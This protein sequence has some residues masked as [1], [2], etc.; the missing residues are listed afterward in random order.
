MIIFVF[1]DYQNS[2]S[3]NPFNKERQ[4]TIHAEMMKDTEYKAV[5]TVY[6]KSLAKE[7]VRYD[8]HGVHFVFIQTGSL[9][10]FN[11]QVLLLSFVSGMGL[12]AVST[13]IVDFI[14][15]KLFGSKVV[16]NNLKFRETS[17]LQVLSHE[18]LAALAEKLRRLQEDELRLDASANE[19]DETKIT[20]RRPLVNHEEKQHEEDDGDD[21]EEREYA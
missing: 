20:L 5:Q 10:R 11:F 2:L 14:S 7:R 15:T 6:T 18:E 3:I 1:I 8:R 21:D 17:N 19:T 16:V 13:T 12:I 4:Y 9:V